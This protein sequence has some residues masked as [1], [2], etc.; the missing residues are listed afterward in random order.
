MLFGKRRNGVV[1]AERVATR[2]PSRVK[3]AANTRET[4]RSPD[5]RIRRPGAQPIGQHVDAV[6]RPLP[7]QQRPR[8]RNVIHAISNST[9][10]SYPA[11]GMTGKVRT[12]TR[13]PGAPAL[14]PGPGSP[15]PDRLAG[16]LDRRFESHLVPHPRAK[17][18]GPG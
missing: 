4:N 12:T 2:Q 8:R 18:K 11:S 3:M 14:P 5:G 16:P 1:S 15:P 10:S 6:Q 13:E 9:I 7:P 17:P